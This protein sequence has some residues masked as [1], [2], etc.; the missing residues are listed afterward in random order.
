[1]PTTINSYEYERSFNIVGRYKGIEF[2]SRKS[3]ATKPVYKRPAVS[4]NEEIG[5]AIGDLTAEKVKYSKIWEDALESLN[6]RKTTLLQNASCCLRCVACCISNDR[7]DGWL[8]DE[9][10][11]ETAM[12]IRHYFNIITELDRHT[13]FLKE[14]S[15]TKS[16]TS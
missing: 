1:M 13:V 12:K 15:Q 16:K 11:H 5:T 10:Y 14:I 9:A 4:M 7:L 3:P 2:E 6:T 8:A